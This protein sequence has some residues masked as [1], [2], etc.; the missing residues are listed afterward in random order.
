MSEIELADRWEKIN[1]VVAEFL[2]G[3]TNPSQIA[4]STG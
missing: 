2:K 1:S 3:N 4:S